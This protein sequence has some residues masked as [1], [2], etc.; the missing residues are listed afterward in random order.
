MHHQASGARLQL[1]VHDAVHGCAPGAR[2]Y[3]CGARCH[4]PSCSGC[5]ILYWCCTMSCTIVHRVHDAIWVVHDAIRV[6]HDLV[7]HHAAGGRCDIC[8]A[9]CPAPWCTSMLLLVRDAM[10]GAQSCTIVHRVHD[11]ILVAPPCR[12][13]T[14]LL[15]WYTMSCTIMDRVQ[16]AI[17]VVHDVLHHWP[18]ARF[19]APSCIGCTILHLWC[20]MVHLCCPMSCTIVNRVICMMLYGWCTMSCTIKRRMQN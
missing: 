9:Q 18:P 4:A 12:T 20:A 5:T 2:H 19:R 16:N 14:M 6:V 3:I 13:C 17:W 8:S 15:G 7:Q 1:V 11:D 10:S